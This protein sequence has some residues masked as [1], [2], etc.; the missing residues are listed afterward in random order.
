MPK[1]IKLVLVCGLP[2]R[3]CSYFILYWDPDPPT[4]RETATEV[5]CWTFGWLLL[6]YSFNSDMLF[7]HGRPSQQLLSSCATN[8]KTSHT[9][10]SSATS[11]R[12]SHSSYL[13]EALKKFLHS[14]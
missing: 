8:M 9:A 6:I 1:R 11:R 2:Q 13:R 7:S 5:G 4:E 12:C 10:T 14:E 3:T